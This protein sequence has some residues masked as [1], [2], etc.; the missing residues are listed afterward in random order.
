MRKSRHVGKMATYRPTFLG[1]PSGGHWE[2]I[3]SGP[4]QG[5]IAAELLPSR[6][7]LVLNNGD[8]I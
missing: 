2:E 1:M 5:N 4:H 8:K 7:S 3:R 6:G